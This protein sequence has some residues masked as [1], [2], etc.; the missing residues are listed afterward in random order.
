[1]ASTESLHGIAG[2]PRSLMATAPSPPP[3]PPLPD[4]EDEED[5]LDSSSEQ[6][7]ISA[8]AARKEIDDKAKTVL[9]FMMPL[10]QNVYDTFTFKKP[11]CEVYLPSA[12]G[13]F[14][15]FSCVSKM[16]A[17]FVFTGTK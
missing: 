4:E 7:G 10:L 3:S 13:D 14:D 9:L 11:I 1:M 15:G 5:E 12:L 2:A 16:F 17:L 8:I 6:P